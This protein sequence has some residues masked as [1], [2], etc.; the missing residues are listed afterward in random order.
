[1]AKILLAV[2]SHDTLGDTGNRTGYSVSE[3]AHPYN[4]FVGAGHEV[5]F[6]SVR[7]GEPPAVVFP[8]EEDDPEIVGF[9]ADETVKAK[10]VATRRAADVDPAGY[11]AIFYV[12][13]HGA[14]WD[15]PDSPDLARIA[16]DIHGR[17]GVVSAVCHGPAALVDLR[18]PDGTLLVSGKRVASFSNEEEDSLGLVEVMPFLL[19]DRLKESG[20]LHSKAPVYQAHT[21]SDGRVV[22][23][24]NPAS[25]APVA[26]LVVA[27]LAKAAETR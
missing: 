24:Q 26:R 20:A 13:G 10:L 19:E 18:L 8:G 21:Q 22:T 7:G 2:S 5:D 15:F 14:M 12:G 16:M 9:L 4:V 17:G 3:A 25:A 23:G 6:V 11:A 27:E 1:M